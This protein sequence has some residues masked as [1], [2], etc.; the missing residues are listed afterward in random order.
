MNTY[1]NNQASTPS[2]QKNAKLQTGDHNY[3]AQIYK[4]VCVD[5]AKVTAAP[6]VL[7]NE[8]VKQRKR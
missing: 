5:E 6:S 8:P 2:M 3:N 4:I 1:R 7:S